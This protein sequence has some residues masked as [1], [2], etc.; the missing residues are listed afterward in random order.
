M[1]C[2]FILGRDFVVGDVEEA[3]VQI[4]HNGNVSRKGRGFF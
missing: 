2:A 1:S 3:R 4:Y